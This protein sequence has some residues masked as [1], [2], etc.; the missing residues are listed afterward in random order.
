MQAAFPTQEEAGKLLERLVALFNTSVRSRD[1]SEYV[2]M[3]QDDAVVDYEGVPERG[4]LEGKPAIAQRFADEPP[5][6][7]V[8][9][10]RWKY[11]GGRILAQF[12]WKDIPEARGG[13]LVIVPRGDKIAHLTI[14]FGGPACRWK[15]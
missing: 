1:F 12:V 11:D 2:E 10:T 9:V 4:P 3:F 5:D 8:R 7:E 13:A 6:D 14:A 15:S